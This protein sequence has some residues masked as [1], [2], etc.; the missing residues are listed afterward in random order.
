MNT[1]SLAISFYC[2]P[3]SPAFNAYSCRTIKYG[4]IAGSSLKPGYNHITSTFW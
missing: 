3:L 1:I 4:W 2:I